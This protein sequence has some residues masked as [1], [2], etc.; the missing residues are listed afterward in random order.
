MSNEAMAK[1]LRGK[2]FLLAT[3]MYGGMC[4]AMYVTSIL[5]LQEKCIALGVNFEHCFMVNESLIDRAR[6]G[7]V[8]EFLAQSNQ[9]YLI[10]ID[11]DI[12]FNPDDILTLLSLDKDVIA[13]PCPKKGINWQAIIAAVKLGNED[14]AYLAKLGGEYNFS[15]PNEEQALGQAIKVFEV[16]TGIMMIHRRVFDKMREA[17]PQNTYKSDNPRHFVIGKGSNV[18]AY[19]KSEIVDGRHLSEDFYFCN[20]WRELEG[21]IWLLPL[22][23]TVHHGSYGFQGSVGHLA[24]L[25][26]R[27]TE[28]NGGDKA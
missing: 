24:E 16:V 9:D 22:A 27:V 8:H 3:P 14:P 1:K 10:F 20:K 13:I 19:F 25:V 17:F 15:A 23:Q 6:N 18:H 26:K 11:G 2:G 21:D 5:R 28:L 7:L 12:Q 4:H